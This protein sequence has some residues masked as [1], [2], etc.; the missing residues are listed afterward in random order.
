M[1]FLGLR[2]GLNMKPPGSPVLSLLLRLGFL[3]WS[4]PEFDCHSDGSST[5]E[6][7]LINK[8]EELARKGFEWLGHGDVALDIGDFGTSV[9][10]S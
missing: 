4:I 2:V 1:F 8:D 10:F 9:S 7:V 6:D 5:G 3:F